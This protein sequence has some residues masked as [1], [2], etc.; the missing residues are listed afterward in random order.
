MKRLVREQVPR[1]EV[2]FPSYVD[3]IHYGL[4]DLRR[5]TVGEDE[6][7][8]MEDIASLLDRVGVVVK[9]VA[10]EFR[11]LSAEDKTG[12]LALRGEHGQPKR[13]GKAVQRVKWLGV[14]LDEG[15]DFD[16]HW[17]SRI[18]KARRLMGGI[19]GAGTNRW[20]MSPLS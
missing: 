19:S 18:E 1:V 13:K 4:Y 16:L 20:G 14:I 7:V 10:E 2:E 8:K 6:V 3:D 9:E 17:E 12:R 5:S 15:L 11:L